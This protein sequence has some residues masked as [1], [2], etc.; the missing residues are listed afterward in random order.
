MGVDT[1]IQYTLGWCVL[2]ITGN[3]GDRVQNGHKGTKNQTRNRTRCYTV[4]LCTMLG[5]SSRVAGL[6]GWIAE[7]QDNVVIAVG[8]GWDWI[9]AL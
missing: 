7:K 1:S 9:G 2:G 8:F 5:E 3:S 4:L 6:A